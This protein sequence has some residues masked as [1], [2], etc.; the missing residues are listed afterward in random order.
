MK[1]SMALLA[2]LRS[3]ADSWLESWAA[4]KQGKNGQGQMEEK[5]CYIISVIATDETSKAV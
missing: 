1:A 5:S 2:L 3:R 4:A